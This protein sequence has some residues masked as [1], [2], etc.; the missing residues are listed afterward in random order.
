MEGRNGILFT[1]LTILL[2]LGIGYYFLQLRS[3]RREVE[4]LR[5]LVNQAKGT[6]QVKQGVTQ[7]RLRA[8]EA[9]RAAV[10]QYKVVA[11][12]HGQLTKDVEA[13]E[14]EYAVIQSQFIEAVKKVRETAPDLPPTDIVLKDGVVL[15]GARVQRMT[16]RD[17]TF[18]HAGGVAKGE[19]KNLPPEIRDRYRQQMP[20]F[21][22]NGVKDPSAPPPAPPAKKKP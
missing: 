3:N 13:L 18:Q 12:E 2:G 21:T 7:T 20:P 15:T 14:A 4:E 6:L 9:D 22:R 11:D 1:C 5:V 17:I 10:D 16:D 19:L 8:L